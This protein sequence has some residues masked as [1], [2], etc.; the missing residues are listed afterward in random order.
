MHVISYII[1]FSFQFR[2][3]FSQGAVTGFPTPL[4]LRPYGAIQ[5]YILLLLLFSLFNTL[6]L[7][8]MGSGLVMR[9]DAF[10]DYCAV[11]YI[12]RLLAYLTSLLTYLLIYVL[13]YRPVRSASRP[14]VVTNS[15]PNISLVFCV[16]FVL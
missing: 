3:A 11:C 13:R 5:M 16:C 8:R 6:T 10:A 2:S 14:E 9:P 7:P 4:K 1:N 15:R 12:N